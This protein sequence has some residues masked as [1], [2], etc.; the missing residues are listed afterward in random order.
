MRKDTNTLKQASKLSQS[1]LRPVS[2]SVSPWAPACQRYHYLCLKGADLHSI[3]K[4]F[5]VSA[6]TFHGGAATAW[7]RAE[8]AKVDSSVE[9]ARWPPRTHSAWRTWPKP[10]QPSQRT[11][12][13]PSQHSPPSAP[14]R[15]LYHSP[16]LTQVARFLVR[17]LFQATQFLDLPQQ[18]SGVNTLLPHQVIHDHSQA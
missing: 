10:P 11:P 14:P 9:A 12:L 4:R 1:L 17:T 6:P 8:A 2:P 16:E 15:N 3:K 7:V 5:S 18:L 13:G